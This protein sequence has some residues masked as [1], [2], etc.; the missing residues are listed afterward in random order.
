MLLKRCFMIF[1][2]L[3]QSWLV[4]AQ[5]VKARE[6]ERVISNSLGPRDALPGS[7]YTPVFSLRADEKSRAAMPG[8]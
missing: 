2:T 6:S 7:G 3:L 5:P 8:F 4:Q 1:R